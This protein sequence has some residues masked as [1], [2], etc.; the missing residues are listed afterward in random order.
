MSCIFTIPM[1]K[2]IF[3]IYYKEF[4]ANKWFCY[5]KLYLKLLN[6]KH[7]TLQIVT[8]AGE[9]ALFIFLFPHATKKVTL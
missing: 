7:T 1:T 9:V 5:V 2:T 6:Y 3:S 8:G 4:N